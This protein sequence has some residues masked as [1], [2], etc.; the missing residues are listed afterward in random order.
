MK[1]YC[2]VCGYQISWLAIF[3][4]PFF[5]GKNIKCKKCQTELRIEAPGKL[6]YVLYV[7]LPF[8]F[9]AIA[10]Y[11]SRTLEISI[12][13]WILILILLYFWM[14]NSRVYKI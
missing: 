7:F 14:K 10:T 13:A 9:S 6:S 8:I 2:V 4:S 5:L 12:P 1:K 3:I 11:K